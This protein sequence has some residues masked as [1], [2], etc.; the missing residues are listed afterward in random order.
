MG[1]GYSDGT[2]EK[3][4][5]LVC[6]IQKENIFLTKRIESLES[7]LRVT[8]IPEICYHTLEEKVEELKDR[9]DETSKSILVEEKCH[10]ET[11]NKLNSLRKDKLIINS[12]L[13]KMKKNALTL[14][15]REQHA[16]NLK[17]T[18]TRSNCDIGNNFFPSPFPEN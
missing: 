8:E 16:E 18:T 10:E 17:F 2:E 7:R 15:G 11:W 5:E 12:R 9:I 4:N 14:G 1:I 6:E 3:Y 13:H